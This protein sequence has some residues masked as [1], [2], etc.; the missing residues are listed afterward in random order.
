M[1]RIFLIIGAI[2]TLL[3]TGCNQSNQGG[4]SDQY[5]SSN[6]HGSSTNANHGGTNSN[7]N[8]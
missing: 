3:L 6:A 1:K 2:A 8:P 5:N 4:A 7:A